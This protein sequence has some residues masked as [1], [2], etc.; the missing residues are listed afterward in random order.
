MRPAARP[1]NVVRHGRQ[2]R[3]HASLF[4]VQL[5]A[6]A[7]VVVLVS[8]VSVAAV[9]VTQL[10]GSVQASTVHLEH[11]NGASAPPGIDAITG[12][13]N[14]LLVG[15]DTRTG[16][17]GAFASRD[18]LAGSSGAGNNDVTILLHIAQNH[19]SAMV[20]SFPRDLILNLPPCPS[21]RGG[22]YPASSDM[23]LNSTLSRGGLACP[24][25][26]I[27]KLTGITIPYAASISFDGVAA[28]SDAVGGVAVCVANSIDDPYTGL[29]LSAGVHTI[30]GAVALAFV[31]T[32]HGVGDGSDLGRISNQQVF[33]SALARTIE[34][35]GVLKNP[36][37]LYGLASA[38]TQNMQ[39]SDSLA[40]LDTLVGIALALKGIP[41]QNIVMIQY[42]TTSSPLFPNRVVPVAFA[43]AAVN[44]ALINDLAVSLTGT[45]GRGAVV[46]TTPTAGA[47]PTPVAVP[48]AGNPNGSTATSPSPAPTVGAPVAVTALPASVT[49]QTAQEQTCSKGNGR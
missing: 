26:T 38:A 11:I 33:L 12:G 16:Q 2:R 44:K 48:T 20:V 15:T 29:T 25:L 36:I 41:L 27:E 40:R 21:P 4:A 22:F 6:I 31:R 3:S 42:P 49:G 39:L 45:T 35:E 43:D 28:M 34:S 32:R 17:G 18:Q 13:V 5:L 14:L 30:Q 7:A 8:V 24:V 19:R 1:E 10:S 47:T 46:E 9:A 23:M 37:Q